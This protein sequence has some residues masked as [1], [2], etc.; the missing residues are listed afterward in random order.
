V[1]VIEADNIY[2]IFGRRP[3]AA[4]RRLQAGESRDDLR[5]EGTTAAALSGGAGAG[6]A[7]AGGSGAGAGSGWR[8]AAAT[9]PR[10]A[11]KRRRL[12]V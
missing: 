11:A 12:A 9:A 1:K 2:K 5:K 3:A 4:V 8:G 10:S 7:G 6:R